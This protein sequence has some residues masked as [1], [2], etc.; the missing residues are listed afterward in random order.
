IMSNTEEK[1]VQ[2]QIPEV[3]LGDCNILFLDVSSS[4]TGFTIA[5]VDFINKKAE[6]IKAGPIWLDTHWEHAKKYDYLYNLVQNYF[7]VVEHIDFIVVEQYS[8][9]TSK[10][11]GVLVSPEAHGAI[12]AAA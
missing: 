3:K 11:S 6:I 4:C 2:E 7:E 12:K 1:T 8:I 9:N 10:M 5:K